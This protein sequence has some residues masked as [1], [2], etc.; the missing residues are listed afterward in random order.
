MPPKRSYHTT[1]T[2]FDNIIDA[3]L[4]IDEL[5]EAARKKGKSKIKIKPKSNKE[6]I[7]GTL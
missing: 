2:N 7:R 1:T 5:I 3:K 6:I 4:N